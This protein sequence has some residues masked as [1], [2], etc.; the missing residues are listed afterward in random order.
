MPVPAPPRP[1]GP[2]RVLVFPAGTEVGLEIGRALER[3]LHVQL[4]GA[5]SRDD[6]GALAFPRHARIP[7]LGAPEFDAQFSALLAQWQI[8][9]VFATHDSV[10]AYLAPRIAAWGAAMLANG[11]PEACRI[12]RS[13][14]A[15]L[16]MFAHTGWVPR[17]HDEA[18]A[19]TQWPV[20]VKPDAGQ[21][22]QGF[23]RADDA[24]MLAQAMAAVSQPLV[25]EYLPGEEISV[26]CFS[27]RHGRLLY[28]GPRSRERVVGGIA[29]RSR[30]L[31]ADA[32]VS[33]IAAA[34][35]ARLALRGPW[36]LQLRRDAHGRWKLLEFSCRL[37]TGSTVARA[38]GVNLPLLMVQDF[39]G[40]DVEVLP[41]PRLRVLERRLEHHAVLD[42]D[43]DTCYFDLDDTLVCNGVANPAAMRLAYRLLERG[44]R[45]VLLTRHAGDIACTLASARIAPGLFDEIVHLREGEPKSAAIHPPSL[46]I[47][48]HFPERLEVSRHHGIPV[49]DVDALDLLYR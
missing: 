49:F 31:P 28:V 23:A 43:F 26:D 44:K 10:Q 19:I 20:A 36:F 18:A 7:P 27:D 35:H 4:H 1:P 5:G 40:R 34:I 41:E 9:L 12:A 29:M 22:G 3:S 32:T 47:D 21:G 38:A 37:S 30:P 14:R 17:R 15:T 6:H 13:K 16:D 46:F 24:A 45:L 33:A 42:Y 8:E 25:T 39:L 2:V 48:N 11:D